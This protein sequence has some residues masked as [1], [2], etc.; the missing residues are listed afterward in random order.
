MNVTEQ[1]YPTNSWRCYK[2]SCS[3]KGWKIGFRED[4]F[5]VIFEVGTKLATNFILSKNAKLN[6]NDA[7]SFSPREYCFASI[8]KIFCQ[9]HCVVHI[10]LNQTINFVYPIYYLFNIHNNVIHIY[11]HNAMV[12]NAIIINLNC[13]ELNWNSP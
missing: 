4:N 6:V 10:F 1:C 13:T 12:I 8:T 2:S 3:C 7:V 11:M 5:I 9:Y